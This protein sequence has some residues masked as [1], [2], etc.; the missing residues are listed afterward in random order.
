MPIVFPI[1]VFSGGAETKPGTPIVLPTAEELEA[2][3][4]ESADANEDNE[5]N[6]VGTEE[7]IASL[8]L[9]TAAVAVRGYQRLPVA[10]RPACRC[11]GPP[12]SCWR[13]SSW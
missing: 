4:G 3:L 11:S 2:Q 6:E 1:G 8:G 7:L 9:G 13:R 12:R 10:S 5:D